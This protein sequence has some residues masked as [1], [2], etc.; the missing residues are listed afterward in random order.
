[1][2]AQ[3]GLQ[4]RRGAAANS[5]STS[6]SMDQDLPSRTSSPFQNQNG[7]SS[8]NNK[9][10]NDRSREQ[11][12]NSNHK[13]AYDPRDLDDESELNQNPKLTLMEECLL[14]GLKDKQVSEM[15]F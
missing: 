2:S 10:L 12:G 14:L 11:S 6:Q 5:G 7:S 4:R 8:S 13:I 9:P 1:M 3:A 15:D